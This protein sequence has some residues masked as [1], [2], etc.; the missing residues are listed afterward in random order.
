M[1][2]L[3]YIEQK[4]LKGFNWWVLRETSEAQKKIRI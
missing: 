2:I 1:D 3:K 4:G